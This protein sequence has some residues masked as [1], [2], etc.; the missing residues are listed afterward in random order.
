MNFFWRVLKYSSSAASAALA[1]KE[2]GRE[3]EKGACSACGDKHI[4]FTQV[5][6]QN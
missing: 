6:R 2:K 5:W 4:S 1:V 3:E